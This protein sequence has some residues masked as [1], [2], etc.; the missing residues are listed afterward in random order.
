MNTDENPKSKIRL[1]ATPPLLRSIKANQG[2][3]NAR[4][5]KRGFSRGSMPGQR[6]AGGGHPEARK[7]TLGHKSWTKD[8]ERL[9]RT[10]ASQSALLSGFDGGTSFLAGRQKIHAGR[11]CSPATLPA[12]CRIRTWAVLRVQ[13][14]KSGFGAATV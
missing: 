8:G 13:C 2:K 10:L 9:S 11:V 1:A 14:A 6:E 7:N 12:S 3:S 5:F 4:N